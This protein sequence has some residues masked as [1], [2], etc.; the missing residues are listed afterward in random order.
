MCPDCPEHF[1]SPSQKLFG[2]VVVLISRR[3]D[4]RRE[5]LKLAQCDKL[6][7]GRAKILGSGTTLL[8]KGKIKLL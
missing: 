7:C 6:P 1:T 4:G 3:E 2:K 8:V 5:A